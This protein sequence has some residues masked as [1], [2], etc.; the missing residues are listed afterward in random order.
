MYLAL[1]ASILLGILLGSI[2]AFAQSPP[3][4]VPYTPNY[5]CTYVANGSD[6]NVSVINAANNVIGTTI[7]VPLFATGVAVSPNNARAYVGSG[8]CCSTIQ[9]FVTVIDTK[10]GLKV[11]DIDLLQTNPTQLAITPDNRFVWVAEAACDGCAPGVQVIDTANNNAVTTVNFSFADPN[12]VAL[13]PDG[14]TAYVA[15]TC[16]NNNVPLTCMRVIDAAFNVIQTI[17]I[18]NSLNADTDHSITVTPDGTQVCLSYRDAKRNFAVAFMSPPSQ[19]VI[20]VSTGDL[21]VPSDFGLVVTP[22]GILYAAAPLNNLNIAANTVYLFD[23]ATHKPAGTIIVGN[24]PAGLTVTSDGQ[25]VYVTNGGDFGNNP[26]NTVYALRGG[27][28]VARITVGNHPQGI[29]AMPSIPPTITTQPA[30]QTIPFLSMATLSVQATG[31]PT[32]TYQWYQGNSGDTSNPIQGATGSSFTTPTLTSTTNFWV[33]VTND[34][35]HFDSRTATVTVL[36]ALPPVITTQPASQVIGIGDTATLSVQATGTLPLSYQWFQGQSGDTS[37]PIVGAT[38][39]TFTTPPLNVSTNYWVQVSNVGGTTNSNTAVITVSTVPTCTLDLRAAGGSALAI[40]ATATCT[41]HTSPPLPLTTTLDWGDNTPPASANGGTLQATHTYGAIA[42]YNVTVTATNSVNLKGV[43]LAVLDL[44]PVDIQPPL[45]VFQG[46]SATFSA[47]VASPGN[48]RV[49]FECTDVVDSSGHL[50]QASD[51]GITCYAVSQP[52]PLSQAGTQVTIVIQ[53]TG[54]ALASRTLPGNHQGLIYACLMPFSGI[55]FLPGGASLFMRRR[56]LR[57]V[58]AAFSVLSMM[59]LVTSCGG[60]FTPPN[61]PVTGTAPGNYH[62]SVIDVLADNSG[63]PV[64]F[65][66]TTLIVP[67]QVTPFQ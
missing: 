67:L 57:R 11:T 6:D 13:S 26:G 33:R 62:V 20:T 37:T 18:N 25:T 29:A 5:P 4:C 50:S 2:T 19:S 34:V 1:R 7:R 61:G 49:N 12:A 30:D 14:A 9:G 47:T 59:L 56:N 65:V 17:N 8:T 41:D 46:Q 21:A 45:V 23:T 43:K 52:I 31:T 15:D 42:A 27:V 38:N 3:A 44:R 66:Q 10:T 53:T 40:I 55:V 54:G 16:F 58:I 36:P 63:N 48:V 39:P 28:I 22:A 35:A 51:L 32:L 64:A 24:G 60:G